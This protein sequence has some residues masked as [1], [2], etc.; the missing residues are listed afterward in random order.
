MGHS[1]LSTTLKYI[2]VKDET[3]L[4]IENPYDTLVKERFKIET[5]K[6]DYD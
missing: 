1:K 6:P 3:L 4:Q 2:R 5:E